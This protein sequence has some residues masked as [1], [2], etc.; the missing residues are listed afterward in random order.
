V[1]PFW[2]GFLVAAVIG[3]AWWFATKDAPPLPG[4]V[5]IPRWGKADAGSART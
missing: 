5:F 4:A 2:W 3:V 1:T